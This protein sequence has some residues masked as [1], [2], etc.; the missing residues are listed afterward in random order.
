VKSLLLVTFILA[1]PACATAQI[2]NVNQGQLDFSVPSSPAFTVLGVNP[3]TVSRPT[4]PN[5]LASSLINGIDQNGNF[6]SGIAMDF[7]PYM[8]AYGGKIGINQYNASCRLE[9]SGINR[10]GFSILRFLTRTQTSFGVTKGASSQD[11]SAKLA[12][13][14]NFTIFD[15][16]DPRLDRSF[17]KRLDDAQAR[18]IAFAERERSEAGKSPIPAP[19]DTVGQTDFLNAQNAE[20]KTLITPLI[21]DEKN[22]NWNRSSWTIAGSPTWSS[23]DG[24]TGNMKWN[25]AGVWTNLGYGFEQVPGLRDTSELIGFF[26]YRNREAVPATTTVAA[27]TQDSIR[28]GGRWI[29]G[30]NNFHLSAESLY[31]STRPE[32]GM[33]QQY[34]QTTIAGEKKLSSGLWFHIGIGGQSGRISGQDQLFILSSFNW[35]TSQEAQIEAGK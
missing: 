7:S 8:L 15:L 24:T 5:A 32:L 26:E 33:P 17:L 19:G 2:S 4:T 23:P 27:T 21:Q 6:Q 13:G 1:L 12:L 35:G 25:G 11:K 30:T 20:L 14:F 29:F 34:L 9:N 31:V 18:A 22:K 3:T 10:C 28:A 16:G